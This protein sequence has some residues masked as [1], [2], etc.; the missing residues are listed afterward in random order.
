[1]PPPTIEELKLALSHRVEPTK[2]LHA[3]LV[4]GFTRI[5]TWPC[6]TYPGYSTLHQT[7]WSTPQSKTRTPFFKWWPI[8]DQLARE[9]KFWP[10]DDYITDEEWAAYVNQPPFWRYD[11][12]VGRHR[13][14][15]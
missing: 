2:R 15:P 1:M 3:P 7:L 13:R 14:E 11:E 8:Y 5:T 10:M 6:S 4:D 12:Y 9:M